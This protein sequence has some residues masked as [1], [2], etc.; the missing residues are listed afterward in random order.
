MNTRRES[1]C[2]KCINY[3]RFIYVNLSVLIYEQYIAGSYDKSISCPKGVLEEAP[4]T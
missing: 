2:Y 4:N 1:V 3:F